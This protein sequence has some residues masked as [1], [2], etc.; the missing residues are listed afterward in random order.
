MAV[1]KTKAKFA[2]IAQKQKRRTTIKYMA[3]EEWRKNR[4]NLCMY[5]CLCAKLQ[6]NPTTSGCMLSSSR[7]CAVRW[8]GLLC[9]VVVVEQRICKFK[10][11]LCFIA[12]PVQFF[13]F[14]FYLLAHF[15]LVAV[16]QPD[17]GMYVFVA[18][19]AAVSAAASTCGT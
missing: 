7:C 2:K 6:K 13:F 3:N 18:R 9:A 8:R 12:F 15:H 14:C 19:S 11:L 17:A 4:A 16:Q 5:I 1:N 10:L